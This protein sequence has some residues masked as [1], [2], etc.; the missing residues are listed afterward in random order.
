MVKPTVIPR[1][2]FLRT[3]PESSIL[4]P[5]YSISPHVS[6]FV[7]LTPIRYV[8]NIISPTLDAYNRY[9][10][11]TGAVTDEDTGFLRI[12]GEQ[13]DRLQSFFLDIGGNAYELIPN[14]QIWP[15]ALNEAIGG[16][17]HHIY[18]VIQDIGKRV[19]GLEFIA[20]MVFLERYF[21]VYD[22]QNHRLGLAPTRYTNAE[23][24]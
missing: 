6:F 8:Y 18:L 24:N 3:L 15:R 10:K 12:S 21:S 22:T 19:P 20:G 11:E 23:I 13:Y 1:V 2:S 16:Q 17:K 5:L 4:G 7:I 14:A 9:I